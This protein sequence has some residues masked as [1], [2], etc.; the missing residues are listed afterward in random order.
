MS[1]KSAHLTP[2]WLSLPLMI[3][4]G[5][6]FVLPVLQLLLLSVR[7]EHTGFTLSLFAR[8]LTDPF[9]QRIA[10]R[11]LRVSILTTIASLILAYPVAL[12]L[13]NLRS[14]WQSVV[15]LIMV[16]PLLTSVVVR[17]LAWVILLA[18]RGIVNQALGAVG[19]GPLHIIYNEGAMVIG[20]THVFFGYMVVSLMTSMRRIDD[21]LYSAAANL[22]ASR[23][24]QHLE[25]TL[26]LSMPGVLVGSLLVFVL[27]ASAYATPSMLGGLRISMLSVE[28]FNQAI[29]AFNWPEAAVISIV[30]FVMITLV[31]WI[32]TRAAEGGRRRV[33]F[34]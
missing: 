4:L 20:L 16:S 5:A 3:F 9:Y 10:I 11:T 23:L 18:R 17:T 26:P 28:V 19:L 1:T 12:H 13:R 27:S 24:R 8:T 22:G 15:I 6:L 31:V 25:I 7:P 34:E 14:R 30:L 33:L 21:S 32:V 2:Y 29:T